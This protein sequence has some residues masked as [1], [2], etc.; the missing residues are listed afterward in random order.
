MDLLE[1]LNDAVTT[2]AG[3]PW[4]YLVVFGVCLI[5]GFFPPVPSETVVVAAAAVATSTGSPLLIPLVAVAAAGAIA[6]DNIAYAIGRGIG[7]SRFRWMRSARV[8]AAI[9]WAR[10][11]L[12]RRGALLIFSARYIPVGRIAVNMTAGATHYPRRRFIALSV[13]AGITWAVYSTVF[14]LV[15]GHWLHEQPILAVILAIVL[16][17]GIGA[18]VDAALRRLLARSA[19]S[20]EPIDAEHPVAVRSGD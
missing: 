18:V 9:E 2:L 19:G 20:P 3:S 1:L 17:A 4:V 15:A 5:D 12:D 14:G 11:G 13:A 7:V 10:R 16:A 8:V 6:G